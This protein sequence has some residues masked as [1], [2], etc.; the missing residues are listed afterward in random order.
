MTPLAAIALHLSTALKP[1]VKESKANDP[2]TL[3]QMTFHEDIPQIE[4]DIQAIAVK[5]EMT[6]KGSN[7]TDRDQFVNSTV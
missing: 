3:A 5:S 1:A 7:N 6:S 4:G 2:F